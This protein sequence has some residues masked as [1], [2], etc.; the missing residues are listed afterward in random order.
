MA[1]DP[2]KYFRVEARELLDGLGRGVLEL[3][4]GA[5]ATETGRRML[6]LAHTLKGAARVVKQPPIAE[7]AHAIEDVLVPYAS[8]S[9]ERLAAGERI[10][11]CSRCSTPSR[12]GVARAGARAPRRR[13]TASRAGAAESLGSVR[14]EIEEMDALLE[15]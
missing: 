1:Q 14:V 13:P 7:L 10:D 6:R 15:G 8:A 9:A 12:R 4:K 11:G 5:G 3:E 2:Y